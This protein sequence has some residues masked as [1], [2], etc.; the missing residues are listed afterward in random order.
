MGQE[1]S[2]L[3]RYARQERDINQGDSMY[4]REKKFVRTTQNVGG[5]KWDQNQNPDQQA[6]F[7]LDKNSVG[8]S[9]RGGKNLY[10]M[11]RRPKR[12]HVAR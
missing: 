11:E 8:R 9:S 6:R 5:T 7:A 10:K 12:F 1:G 3:G 2:F 4:R